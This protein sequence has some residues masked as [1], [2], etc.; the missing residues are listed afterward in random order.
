MST[1]L[2]DVSGTD[3]SDD[4]SAN[5]PVDEQSVPAAGIVVDR[6]PLS[7]NSRSSSSPSLSE[8]LEDTGA[9]EVDD[10]A[11][12]T[13]VEAPTMEMPTDRTMLLAEQVRVLR[14]TLRSA[15]TPESWATCEQAW[16]QAVA[17]A[18][19]A[20]RLPPSTPGRPARDV[21]PDNATEI[22]RLYRRNRRRA[23]RLIMEGPTRSCTIPI[24][25][26]QDHW[27][28]TW[29]PRT[30]DTSALFQRPAAP[31]PVNTASFSADE[32][33]L[34]LR[35]S[36]NTAPGPDRLTYQHW[37]SVDPEARFLSSLFNACVHHRRTP[38]SWR[39]SRTVLIY[40]KGDP[41]VPGNW[42]PIALGCT[43]SK[44]YAKC[45]ASRLQ[46]WIMDHQVLS[47]CQKGFLPYDGVF[48][49]NYIFQ[50]RM[51][52]AR[53]GGTEFCAALLDFANA[54]GSVPHQA[55]LDALRGSGAGETFTALIEDLYRDNQTV[56]VAA[57]GTTD[58]VVIHSGLRQGCPLSGLLFN[59]VIDPVVRG[60]QGTGD[61][62]NIL[63][64]ADD[65]TPLADCPALLQQRIDMVE[66]LSTPL[67]LSLNPGKCTTL[68]LSGVTP[69]GMRP[70]VFRV[71]GVPVTALSDSEPLR[72][73]GRPV[74]FRLPQ[75]AGANVIEDAIRN[76][77]AIFSSLLA[78]WQRID[79]LKTFVFPALNFSMR[80]GALTKTDWHRLDLA[81]R[82]MVKRTLYL[83]V[84]ASTNYV[85][86]SASGGAV[87]IPVA[88]ELYDI[89]RIDSAFKLLT[90]SD[91]SLRDLALSDAY[92]IASTRLG[93][94][95]TRFE[96]E[97]YLSGDR[98]VV[99]SRPATQLRSVWTE[100]RKASRRLQVSWSLRPDNVT[101]TCGD[102]TLP[103]TQRNRVMR[104]LRDVLA[105]VR[106]N[107]LHDQPNQ[108]KVM[109]CVS[110]DRASS[111]F[112]STGA[113]THFADWRFIHRA[114]LNLLPLNGAVMWGPTDRDQRCRV[115][116]YAR[117]TLPHVL[118]HCMTHSAMSQA[119]HNAVVSRLRTAAARD[120]TVA[121]ENRP[122]GDTGLR[123]DLVLVR[124]EEALVIDVACPFENTPEASKTLA[125]RTF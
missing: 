108:G 119:R 27:A 106:D 49:L 43:A 86:G 109:A 92:E 121:Y 67:G 36:E 116:G 68:H 4:A 90:T 63:A 120:Y 15:P 75:R 93:W 107:A 111:H 40:K 118:C 3:D 28:S 32:V 103:S 85:Y 52:A 29:S 98:Q 104:T 14:A 80:C 31:V 82:P 124:G 13:P 61:D 112:I 50:H 74:G 25:D 26:I 65:L 24:R 58:P 57:E 99:H 72:Y 77:T 39:T 30:A 11:H 59:L 7:T 114:R 110:A 123:P 51:D 9:D 78:P 16:S 115:C 48:E 45:L 95:A 70:T 53:A 88:A 101:I 6:R 1:E 20:V 73:L 84:N 5:E 81:I 125:L 79:A 38:D 102:A 34:R 97:A 117:E 96:L 19:E 10:G 18:A 83:P 46:A 21:N 22:Q 60:V 113:F 69:V 8:R 17:L 64:Y 47:R 91:Q 12:D 66:A 2:A 94:E 42:R 55:L 122:V 76:A 71:S 54:Y 62:H 35:K 87:A 100:A 37:R 33:L 105:H 89:C 23:V 44:L 41:S 56:I